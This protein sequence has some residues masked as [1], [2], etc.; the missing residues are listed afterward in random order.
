MKA[1]R[2]NLRWR[3]TL[4]EEQARMGDERRSNEPNP[5]ETSV[6][7]L[8]QGVVCDFALTLWAGEGKDS[9]VNGRQIP[10]REGSCSIR[11]EPMK[12]ARPIGK[13]VSLELRRDNKGV[14]DWVNGKATEKTRLTTVS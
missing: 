9:H 7:I 2:V 3:A 12:L 5:M 11:H 10:K 13:G 1:S 8:L 14:V 6:V 4:V